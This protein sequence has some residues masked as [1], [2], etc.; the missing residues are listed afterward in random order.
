M[1]TLIIEFVSEELVPIT[2]KVYPAMMTAI[3]RVARNP[4]EFIRA[5]IIE[6]LQKLNIAIDPSLTEAPSR[7][8]VGGK[9][10]HRSYDLNESEKP[11]PR[12]RIS[13]GSIGY[14]KPS[15]KSAAAVT[16]ALKKASS[17]E[18]DQ[19]SKS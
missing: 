2:V 19:K 15:S 18:I 8:G 14:K 16:S 3:R 1:K 4:S 5:A 6:R 17:A 9:P 11:P 12:P 10:T 13:G 7:Q